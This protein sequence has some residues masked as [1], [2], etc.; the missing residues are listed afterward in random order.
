M[1]GTEGTPSLARRLALRLAALGLDPRPLFQR[2]RNLMLRPARHELADLRRDFSSLPP[3]LAGLRERVARM[4]AGQAELQARLARLDA[5]LNESREAATEQLRRIERMESLLASLADATSPKRSTAETL[6]SIVLPVRNR[7][8]LV[9]EA[10]DSVVAQRYP[11]W[12]LIVVDDGSEDDTAAAVSAYLKDTRIRLERIASAGAAA[13]RNHGLRLSRGE[14]IAY[15]DSDNLWY[16][17]FLDAAVAALDADASTALLYGVLLSNEHDLSGGPV[18]FEEFDRE[19]LLQANYIDLNTVVHRRGLYERLGG[20][21]EGLTRLID[22]DLLLRYT[23][24]R[25]AY[26]L[27]AFAARYRR[28]DAQR[29][30][31]NEPAGPNWLKLREKNDPLPVP[32]R[33]PKILYVVWH[34]PQLSE[35][36]LEGEIRCM[37]RMGVDIELWREVGPASPYPASVPVHE[38]DLADVVARVR[39]DAIHVHW[40]GYAVAQR[41]MLERIGL[42]LTLRMHGFDVTPDQLAR[43]LAMPCLHRVYAFPAQLQLPGGDDP[44]MRPVRSAFDTSY[45]SPAADK[46][47]HLVVR[48]GACLPS[49]DIG[50]FFDVA[51]RCPRHRFVFAGVTCNEWEPYVDELRRLREQMQSPVELRFDVPREETAALIGRAGIYLHTIHPPSAPHGAP[52]GMPISIAEAMSTGCYPLVRN[53]PE[54][55][56]YVGDAGD[57]YADAAD[58][59]R[60]VQASEGW[61]AAEWKARR[62]R[63]IDRAYL[64]HADMQV[65]RPI[66]LDWCA[67]AERRG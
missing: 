26:A 8:S 59:T 66:Y 46:D 30:T 15:L 24:E 56:A 33:R 29:I 19:R 65:L 6:V 25:A 60:L 1:P 10:I 16:P 52:I 5:Q 64:H 39:P 37:L 42:P 55:I 45:F 53:Q 2:V 27:P 20:F 67:L 49:K 32:T 43:L 28:A 9:G 36:Y 21:D 13:A 12:E 63:A 3:E 34:Y 41:E 7:A 54:L 44:R 51:K 38:G 4:D 22:W 31:D 14:F 11:H 62:L 57:A 40:L 35:S 48:A 47:P 50:L 58:A 18:L 61:S 23:K 17:G